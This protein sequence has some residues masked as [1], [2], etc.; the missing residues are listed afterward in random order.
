M[1]TTNLNAPRGLIPY[2]HFD[3]SYY[4]GSGNIYSIPTSIATNL[5]IGDPVD[6]V[7]GSNDGSGIPSVK[8]GVTGS[9][10][11]GAIIGIADGGDP[12]TAVTRDL[13]IYHP[14]STLQYVLV[15]DDPTLIFMIQDDA[16]AQAVASTLWAGKNASLITGTGSTI[17]GYSGWQLQSSTVIAATATLDLKI[18][19]P[20]PQPDNAV[21]GTA[22]TNQN[23]KWLVKLNNHRYANQ[24]AGV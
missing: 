15:A 19:R 22:N 5:F 2:R 16:S 7:S 9:P 21:S 24:L 12:V 18:M 23:A 1:A 14:A 6:I 20:L 11:I 8:I 3:G 10:I 4:N 17:T 13:P